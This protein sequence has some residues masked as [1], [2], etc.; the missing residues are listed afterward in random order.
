M[1]F[2]RVC[3][4]APAAAALLL[5]L[6][7]APASAASSPAAWVAAFWPSAKAAGVSRATYDRAFQGFVPDPDVIADANAQPEFTWKVWD[8]VDQLVS[9]DRIAQG[10]AIL[11]KYADVLTRIE[12]RYKVDRRVIVAIW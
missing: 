8:Y 12:A 7:P 6:V 5:F 11:E 9:D 2:V 10:T 4:A 3:C 1:N